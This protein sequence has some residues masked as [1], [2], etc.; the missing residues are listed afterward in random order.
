MRVTVGNK[1]FN[2][3]HSGRDGSSFKAWQQVQRAFSDAVADGVAAQAQ[4]VAALEF[5]TSPGQLKA[6]VKSL[7]NGANREANKMFGMIV[8][9]IDRSRGASGVG[10][11]VVGVSAAMMKVGTDSNKES[12]LRLDF[13]KGVTGFTGVVPWQRLSVGW[14][15]FKAKKAPANKDKF[16]KGKT[17]RLREQLGNNGNAYMREWFGGVKVTSA[18]A[19]TTKPGGGPKP[20]MKNTAAT[21]ADIEIHIFPKVAPTLFPGLASRRW[22]DVDMD[23]R[24][25]RRVVKGEQMRRKLING[26]V[27]H[28]RP[29]LQPVA[30]F[31]IMYRIPAVIRTRLQSWLSNQTGAKE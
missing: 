21:L 31:W 29:L 23:G 9:I 11:P 14:Q 4:E 8:Q 6:L 26:F 1:R 3:Q 7:E 15:T 27:P 20:P 17:G 2:W 22:N 13:P 30:Q 24:L 28:K 18:F 12:R 16:F 10:R 19:A 25:E 5:K